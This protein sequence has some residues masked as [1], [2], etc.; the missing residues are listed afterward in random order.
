MNPTEEANIWLETIPRDDPGLELSKCN[1]R[2]ARLCHEAQMLF[3]SNSGDGWWMVK[4]LMVVKEAILIDLQYQQWTESLPAPWR[5][6][7]FRKPGT[8]SKEELNAE[9]TSKKFPHYVYEDVYVAWASNNCRAT[10][11]HLHEVLLHCLSL[12]Q[13][14]PHAETYFNAEQT[15]IKSR[16]IIS[17]MIED[18]C[19]CTD[20][21]LGD[22]DSVGD[23][24]ATKYRMPLRGYLMV[25]THWR[26]YVSAPDGSECKLWLRSKLEFISNSMGIQAAL[27]VMRRISDDP[28]DMRSFRP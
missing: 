12:I 23:A 27:A 6:R 14:H 13:M 1:L 9:N 20:F 24:A 18:I 26:A 28:W 19:A 2:T 25:W 21:C 15:R 5:P 22:I 17:E 10:R 4:M 7:N 16:T 8:T 3:D 11:I